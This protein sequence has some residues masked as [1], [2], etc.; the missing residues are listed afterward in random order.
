MNR[1]RCLPAALL[2]GTV[3][4]AGLAASPA[5]AAEVKCTAAGVTFPC[6]YQIEDVQLQ[7]V[8]N[9]FKFQARVAQSKLPVGDGEIQTVYADV[10]S[11]NTVI[12]SE[13]FKNVQVK[14]SVLNL[15]IGANM[16]C[17]L[18]EV[19][20]ENT[21]LTF[22][23]CLGS[24]ST[25]LKPVQ[26]GSTPYAIKSTYANL[27]QNAHQAN[28][29]AV[30]NYAYR[31]TA[32]TDLFL[33]KTLGIGYFD[34]STPTQTQATA[35]YSTPALFG[36]YVD[37]AFLQWTPVRNTAQRLLHIAGRAYG[38]AVEFLDELVIAAKQ[39]RVRGAL[40]ITGEGLPAGGRAL[41]VPSGIARVDGTLEV[42]STLSVP[43]GTATIATLNTTGATTLGG[44]LTANG[45]STFTQNA[46]FGTVAQTNPSATPKVTFNMPVVFN[47][48]VSLSGAVTITDPNVVYYSTAPA[49]NKLLDLG[50]A[51]NVTGTLTAKSA[52]VASG[53]SEFKGVV[54][55]K[56]TAWN[57]ATFDG[58]AWFNGHVILKDLTS[59]RFN[60]GTGDRYVLRDVKDGSDYRLDL[61]DTAYIE[62]WSQARRF[63]S[64]GPIALTSGTDKRN[65]LFMAGGTLE[66]GGGF[67]NVSL[68]NKSLHSVNTITAA[69]A[70]LNGATLNGPST[71]NGSVTLSASAPAVFNGTATFGNSVTFNSAPTFTNGMVWAPNKGIT[72][73]GTTRIPL[74]DSTED[75][76]KPPE[77]FLQIGT[78]YPRV[79][80]Y[81]PFQVW[82]TLST[83]KLTVSKCRICLYQDDSN[84][85]GNSI[86][87]SWCA[88]LDANGAWS[89]FR[90]VAGTVNP[91]DS[92]Q[93][94]FVCDNGPT[95]AWNGAPGN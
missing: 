74:L 44:A 50:G 31:V 54:S 25:C 45:E 3:A 13:Q 9:V 73:Q 70:T 34:F 65:A 82:N 16:T 24:Q 66:V 6:G 35:L 4:I 7:K 39:V 72:V 41:H 64:A 37:S 83:D 53:S 59:L 20:A 63:L 1:L 14:D 79:I 84:G 88:K 77:P 71:F 68:A 46:R 51:L 60:F 42:G 81:V 86:D 94:S 36:K 52:L 48:A 19:V 5:S 2:L 18:G 22:R 87:R 29:A 85:D 61:G 26:L 69:S 33:R 91:D 38:G 92:L 93:I 32:D 49:V 27:A 62:A 15:S 55:F 95:G 21:D 89:G 11:N 58:A 40:T 56:S 30:A 47:G 17:D 57:S 67:N 28:Q 10:L 76:A 75:G 8:P 90:R 78:N 23:I 12:C 43:A 80:S